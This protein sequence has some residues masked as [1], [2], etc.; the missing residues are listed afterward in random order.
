[1]QAILQNQVLVYC[2]MAFLVFGITQG[3]KWAVVKPWTN[4]LKNERA[5]KAINTIIFFF[6]YAVGVFLEFMYSVVLMNGQFN[7]FM[8]IINGGAGHS[9][10]ALY[11]R[12]YAVVTGNKNGKVFRNLSKEEK[13]WQEML[14]GVADDG[15]IDENDKDALQSFW[16]KIGK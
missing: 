9:A 15:K 14:L 12:I 4:K 7:A 2:F 6:P 1:M 8:G 5:R 11:E 13:E 10:Y 3:L 16:E